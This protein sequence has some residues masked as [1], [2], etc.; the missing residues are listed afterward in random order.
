MQEGTGGTCLPNKGY[1]IVCI[2]IISYFLNYTIAKKY[3]TN[4]LICCFFIF[5]TINQGCIQQHSITIVHCAHK[6]RVS[7]TEVNF[8]PFSLLAYV[9]CG[10][11]SVFVHV[12]QS[13]VSKVISNNLFAISIK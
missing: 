2:H 12:P 9:V 3:Y 5:N 7:P 4:I 1:R 10:M 13:G 11:W 6:T 8:S